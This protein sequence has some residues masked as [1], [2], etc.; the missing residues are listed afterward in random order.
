MRTTVTLDPDTEAAVRRL[1]KERRLTFKQAVNAAIR[2]GA[3][4]RTG[5][6]SYATPTYDMGP[7]TVPIDHALRLAAELENE[8]LRRKL[9][10]RK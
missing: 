2:A 9:A 8:E 10:A 1:M 5:R 7:P 6:A 4:P 3:K